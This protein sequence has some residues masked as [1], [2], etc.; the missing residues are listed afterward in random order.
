M[1]N[2]QRKL[3]IFDEKSFIFEWKHDVCDIKGLIFGQKLS[4]L[5]TKKFKK[6]QYDEQVNEILNENFDTMFL[7]KKD[8]FPIQNCP[9]DIKFQ[10][11]NPQ[12]FMIGNI[13][14]W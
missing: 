14:G 13:W 10:D 12:N 8:W 11:K 9:T 6:Y 7:A 1:W 2:F 3:V 5:T 4:F